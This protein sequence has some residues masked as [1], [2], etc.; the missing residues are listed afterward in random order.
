MYNVLKEDNNMK[1]IVYQ[2]EAITNLHVGSG[3]ANFGVVD[4]LIQK[5]AA[6]GSLILMHQA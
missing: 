1:T 4:R 6:T 2:I 5:D 3:E